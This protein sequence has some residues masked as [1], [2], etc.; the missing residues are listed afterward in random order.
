[1]AILLPAAYPHHLIG[2]LSAE[3]IF[4]VA[5]III[6]AKSGTYQH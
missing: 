1:M 4:H 3:M 2:V 5:M 6:P